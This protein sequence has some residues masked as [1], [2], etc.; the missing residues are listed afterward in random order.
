[1]GRFEELV[2]AMAEHMGLPLAGRPESPLEIIL[3]GTAVT[4]SGE[5]ISDIEDIVLAANVGTVSRHREI[6]LYRLLLEANVHWSATRF[7]TLGVNSATL[8]VI[9]CYRCRAAE[10]SGE[11]LAAL[12]S[13]FAETARI[14][15]EIIAS[16]NE[17][18]TGAAPD[19]DMHATMTFRA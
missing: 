5:T 12:L 16:E 14:W 1:M 4:L 19:P 10:L 15:T 8:G 3:G 9:L 18:E 2:S 17:V 13:T 7:A 6:E 11:T